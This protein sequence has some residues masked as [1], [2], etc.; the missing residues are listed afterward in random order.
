MDTAP[1]NFM[2]NMC[3]Y[4]VHA[5]RRVGLDNPPPITHEKLRNMLSEMRTA[6]NS[7][8]THIVIYIAL[9]Y[10][11]PLVTVNPP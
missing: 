8:K 4:Q 5:V 6:K 1:C 9:L 11:W 3:L 2:Y 7:R 10:S